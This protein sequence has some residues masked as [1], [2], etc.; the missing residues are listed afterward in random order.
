MK[1]IQTNNALR[2]NGHYSQAIEH[3]GFVFISGI[4]PFSAQ[5]GALITGNLEAQVET[6]LANL[7]S[8]LAA[9]GTDKAHVLKT[10]I[11]VPDISLWNQVNDMYS[12]YFGDHRPARSIVPTNKLHFDSCIE[13]EAIAC[14]G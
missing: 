10:T 8:I 9:A 12:A 6:V 14:V 7:D 11:Y 13:M 1:I 5:T 3:H 2:A 4:L